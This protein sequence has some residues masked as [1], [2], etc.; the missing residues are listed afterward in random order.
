MQVRS[1]AA[2]GCCHCCCCSL[3]LRLRGAFVAGVEWRCRG[4]GV[5]ETNLEM[6][7]SC[8]R[9]RMRMWNVRTKVYHRC[10]DSGFQFISDFITRRMRNAYCTFVVF[11]YY[12]ILFV[13]EKHSNTRRSCSSQRCN[14]FINNFQPNTFQVRLRPR[15][16]H[17]PSQP[18][19]FGRRSRLTPEPYTNSCE[20]LGVGCCS[21][22]PACV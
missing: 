17:Y 14:N 12:S 18:V 5:G 4:V 3:P 9:A 11:M 1:T 13:F 22:K 21:G 8:A 16:V 15:F 6:I 19:L 20:H 7:H 2:P 10:S